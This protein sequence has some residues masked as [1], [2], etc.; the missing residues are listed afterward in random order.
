[1]KDLNQSMDKKE[2]IKTYLVKVP[3][4]TSELMD[5]TNPNCGGLN[6]EEMIQFIVDKISAYNNLSDKVSTKKRNKTPIK[7]I[8]R[9]VVTTHKISNQSCVLLKISASNTNHRDGYVEIQGKQKL[10][11][12]SKIGSDNIFVLV[13]PNIIGV[14]S[15]NYKYQWIFM[16]YEDPNKENA[17]IVSTV[18]LMT[19]KVLGISIAN[20]KLP[21]MLE[22]LNRIGYIPQM[23]LNLSSVSNDDNDVDVKL[24]QYLVKGKLTVLKENKFEKVPIETINELVNDKN[25]FL[26]FN[27]R[28]I[29]FF[30]GKKEYKLTQSKPVIDEAQGVLQ[31]T[32]E[33]I[34][35]EQ[36]EVTENELN[37]TI[38]TNDFILAKLE[39]ILNKYL[40]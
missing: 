36:F 10:T 28:V 24:R 20:I 23:T 17:D 11:K 4:Y 14:D 33:E 6:Y 22:E 3:V 16:I 34:F 9:I 32:V 15:A 7:Q 21:D 18:K 25:F 27:R 5:K 13:V 31:E 38:Y 2:K 12:N 29:K 1:M 39:P 30:V 37:E 19:N 40:I 35:N 8:D 26:E